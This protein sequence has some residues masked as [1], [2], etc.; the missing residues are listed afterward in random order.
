MLWCVVFLFS[1]HLVYFLI[2]FESS[3]LTH[4]LFKSMWFSFH[5]FGDFLPFLLSIS[6]LILL[7][8]KNAV[9]MIP[10]LL[11]GPWY[12]PPSNTFCRRSNTFHSWWMECEW[13]RLMVVLRYTVSLTFCLVLPVVERAILEV[14]V[15]TCLFLLSMLLFLPSQIWKLCCLMHA[16][17]E[18]IFCVDWSIYHYH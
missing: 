15:W 4:G 3:S 12:D 7:W 8:L 9:C 17:L 11:N 5:M 6:S 10:F 16:H 1:F 18:L 14:S 13:C 2:Y